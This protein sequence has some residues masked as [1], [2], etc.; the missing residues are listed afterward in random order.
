MKF[1]K[2]SFFICVSVLGGCQTTTHPIE[3]KLRADD[4]ACQAYGFIYGSQNYVICRKRRD[5]TFLQVN[6]GGRG[7]IQD[8]SST[9]PVLE[10]DFITTAERSPIP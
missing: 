5:S 10:P 6:L 7:V 2:L 3:A 4:A 9:R 8:I 1:N